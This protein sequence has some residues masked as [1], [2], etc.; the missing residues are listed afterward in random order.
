LNEIKI[1]DYRC[2]LIV[3]TVGLGLYSY[4]VRE[5]LALLTLFSVAF[6]FF[7]LV[8]LGGLLVWSASLQVAAWAGPASRGMLALSHRWIAAYEKP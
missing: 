8:A 3:T 6:F 2:G 7:T 1:L 5:L 4:Y